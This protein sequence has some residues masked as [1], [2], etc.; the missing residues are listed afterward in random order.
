MIPGLLF[1]IL[2]LSFVL[3]KA[4][5]LVIIAIRRL[6]RDLGASSFAISAIILAL[7]TS[8]PELFVGLTSAIEGTPNLSFGVVVGSNIANIALVGALAAIFAGSVEV[9]GGYLKHDVW[10][11]FVAGIL[12]ILLVADLTLGRVDGFILLSVY[13]AYATGFFRH[14]YEKI[15]QEQAQESFVY[16]FFREFNHVDS[17]KTKEF[18]RLFA[19]IALLLFSADSIVRLSTN[20]AEYARIPIFLIGLFVIAIGTSLPE[21]AFSIRSLKDH[22]PSMFFGNLL[23]STIANSTFIVGLTAVIH[24]IKIVAFSQYLTSAIFFVIVFLTFW[25]F[26]RSKHRLD[27]W[28]AGLLFLIYIVF[29]IAEFV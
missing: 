2:I 11:S 27:R 6:S 5:E 23:G 14:R 7:G 22:E 10:I 12:P 28:E 8:F 9:R 3:I 25:F 19:G 15:G 4:A 29:A 18:G 17:K 20:L 13:F 24:P 21:L 1:L 26:I 16:R